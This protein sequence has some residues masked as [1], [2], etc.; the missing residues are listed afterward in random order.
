MSKVLREFQSALI[1]QAY[2]QSVK[3]AGEFT[4]A[5]WA[6]HK[7]EHPGADIKDHTITKPEGGSK[8]PETYAKP[9]SPLD[10]HLKE[11]S[12]K[13]KP[14]APAAAPAKKKIKNLFD[15][16]KSEIVRSD[17]RNSTSRNYNPNALGLTLQRAQELEAKLK[18]IHDSDDDAAIDS[19]RKTLQRGFTHDFAPAKKIIKELDKMQG[20]G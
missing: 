4:P 12:K 11:K 1:K 6:A 18:D 20:K 2:V 8:K 17:R 14:S 5:E 9:G 16:L 19:L 10:K 3:S 13:E 15:D 7:K